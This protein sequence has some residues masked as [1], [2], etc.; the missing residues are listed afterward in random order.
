MG[1]L[2][3]LLIVAVLS[4]R[5]PLSPIN[6]NPRPLQAITLQCGRSVQLVGWQETQS[7]EAGRGSI[8]IALGDSTPWFLVGNEGIRALYMVISLHYGPFLRHYDKA[9][10]HI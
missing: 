6:L 8:R 4:F 5:V 1:Q 2:Q 7:A 10:P 9:P 3:K